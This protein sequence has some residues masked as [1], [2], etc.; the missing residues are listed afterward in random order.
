[1]EVA[2][3]ARN[4][5]RA[6]RLNEDLT[7]TIAL[8]HDLGHAPFGHTGETALAR[9]MKGHGGFEHNSQSL[10][11]VQQLEQKYPAFPGLNLSWEVR[12]G[13]VKHCTPHDHP[14]RSLGFAAKSPSLEA[15]VANLADEIAYYSHDLDDGIDSRLLAEA[16]LHREVRVWHQA[17]LSVR[18][19]HGDLP[20]E[21]RRYFT[22]RCIIDAEVKDVVRSTEQRLHAGHVRHADDV[23]R[24]ARPLV[25]Y[26]PQRRALNRELRRYLYQHVY[27][28]PRVHGPN[29]RAVQ[30]LEDLFEHFLRRPQ[31]MGTTAQKRARKDGLQRAVCDYLAGMTDRYAMLEHRRLFGPAE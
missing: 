26:S 31:D 1:M 20:D 15:Q 27:Y 30:M 2:A 10:R 23:R 6:L 29:L 12:E 3:I 8:A 18:R 21:C 5:A 7:E 14:R 28:S 16:K 24:A 17:A 9:L 4:I 25:G 11:V 22:I 19:E 13:L